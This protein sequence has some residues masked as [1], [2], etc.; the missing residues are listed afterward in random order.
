VLIVL[1]DGE[2]QVGGQYSIPNDLYFNG[3]SGV[4]TNSISAP[5]ITRPDGTSLQGGTMD[6]S[7]VKPLPANGIGYSNDVNAFQIGVCN[8]IKRSGVTIYAIT[9]GSVS[10][11]AAATMQSCST[12]GDYYHAPDGP[13]LTAIF[14]QIAG[15]LGVLRL[16]Q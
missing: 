13:T 15:N 7:E 2:N 9:F 3:L 16:T 8:A 14:D 11:T 1:T 4:G 12:S 5:T 10:A 6:Y